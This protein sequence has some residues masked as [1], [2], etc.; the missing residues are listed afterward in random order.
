LKLS[1]FISKAFFKFFIINHRYAFHWKFVHHRHYIDERNYMKNEIQKTHDRAKNECHFSNFDNWNWHS[2]SIRFHILTRYLNLDSLN[3]FFLSRVIFDRVVLIIDR[4]YENLILRAVKS[5]V[6]FRK[7]DQHFFSCILIHEIKKLKHNFSR[8]WKKKKIMNDVHEFLKN[9]ILHA[10][11]NRFFDS[12]TFHTFSF[13][14]MKTLKKYLI[15][16]L[17]FI[18]DISQRRFST[19]SS[20]LNYSHR[21]DSCSYSHYH[22]YIHRRSSLNRLNRRVLKYVVAHFDEFDNALHVDWDHCYFWIFFHNS[23]MLM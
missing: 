10:L 19:I 12:S 3:D 17:Y 14:L 1:S 23:S 22:C 4:R 18:N 16:Y 2:S 9:Q 5:N 6:H 11:Q 20:W 8:H 15:V 21:F 13:S 7:I